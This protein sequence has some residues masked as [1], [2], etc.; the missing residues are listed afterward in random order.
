MDRAAMMS[1]RRLAGSVVR[2]HTWPMLSRETV[3]HHTW[4]VLRIWDQMFGL[5]APDVVR[6]VLYHDCGEM[7]T[8]D[9]PFPI[10]RNNPDLKTVADRIESEALVNMGVRMRPMTATNKWK[11]KVCDLLEMMEHAMHEMRMGNNF[12]R[13]IFEDCRRAVKDMVESRPPN[14]ADMDI[15]IRIRRHIEGVERGTI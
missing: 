6:Q 7:A 5:P 12:A 3:A 8:G 15:L 9:L 14:A 10:K 2:Y 4:N 11:L 1:N 13:P